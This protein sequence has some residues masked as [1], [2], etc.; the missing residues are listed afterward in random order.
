MSDTNKLDNNPK[1]YRYSNKVYKTVF[2]TTYT[3]S[4]NII[5]SFPTLIFFIIDNYFWVLYCFTNNY[6]YLSIMI[7]KINDIRVYDDH[8]CESKLSSGNLHKYFI[9]TVLTN[10]FFY[11]KKYL[12]ARKNTS[13]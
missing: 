5:F 1:K 2:Q 7:P 4:L 9:K 13:L 12:Q 6:N 3:Y 10:H 8:R 11:F